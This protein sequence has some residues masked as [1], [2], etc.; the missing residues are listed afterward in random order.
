LGCVPNVMRITRAYIA[1]I[2]TTGSLVAAAAAVFLVASAVIA[3]NGWPGTGFADRI[4]SIFV[5]DEPAVAWDQAGTAAVATG[6]GTAAGAVTGTPA[7]PTFG[8]PGLL[9]AD[10]G[11]VLRG[12]P[13]R[14]PD[15]TIARDLPAGSVTI[16]GTGGGAAGDGSPVPDVGP[17]RNQLADTVEQVGGNAGHTVRDTTRRAGNVV[18]GPAGST[19]T[20]AGDT[21]GGTVDQVTSA[22]GDLLRP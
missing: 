4:D 15:G 5:N 1:G 19:V 18:G 10:D 12:G 22:A 7:G 8:E 2:G 14:L 16:P 21:V 17:T 3:F 9:L 13:V 20:H 6:A 11:T